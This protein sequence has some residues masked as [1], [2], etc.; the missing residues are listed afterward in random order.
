VGRSNVF[1]N[2]L[3]RLWPLGKVVYWLGNRPLVGPLLRPFFEVLDTEAIIIPVQEAVQG[4][5]NVVLPYPL[6]ASILKQASARFLMNE[7]LCRCGE[8]CQTYP[9]DLGCLFLGEA[10]TEI[11]PTQG[12]LVDTDE[13]LAHVRRSMSIGLVPLVV[14]ST[15]DAWS[16]GIAYRRMLSV[17]FCCDCCCAVRQGLRLGPPAFWETVTRLP[18]LTLEVSEACV[19]CGACADACYVHAVAMNNGRAS[20]DLEQCKGCGR[21]IAV[22]PTRAISLRMDETVDTL[23][24][25]LA[26]IELRTDI[27]RAR[28]Q[29]GLR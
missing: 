17:C 7:C 14:H 19:S 9:H 6:L 26:R 18:G 16:L 11:N 22:C 20:M 24:Q 4:G 27:G 15:F 5:E 29:F 13:A 8:N 23:G 28:G 21:C 10:V 12:R 3:M 2:T 25:I 1:Y